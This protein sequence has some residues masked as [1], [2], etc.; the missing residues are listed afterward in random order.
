MKILSAAQVRSWDQYTI[1]HEPISSLNLME[2]AAAAC[3]KWILEYDARAEHFIVVCGK[4]NNGGD[5]LALARL[6]LLENYRVSVYIAEQG[7]PGTND[8]QKNLVRLREIDGH[9]ISFIHPYSELPVF[10]ANTVIIDALFGTG[11]TR[12]LEGFHAQLVTHINQSG[13]PVLSID[14]P[15]GLMADSSSIGFPRIKATHTLS[16]QTYKLAFLL[17]ENADA[18]GQVHILEIGLHVDY[19]Q[20][21]QA[22]ME[23]LEQH[24]I[25]GLLKPR[26][27][28]GHKGDYGKLLLLAGSHGKMGAAV[29]AAHAAMRSGVAMLTVHIPKCGYEIL[30][31]SVPEA[32]VSVDDH[33]SFITAMRPDPVIFDAIGI[34]PGIGTD[35]ETASFMQHLLER[36]RHPLVLDAD[37]LNI[38]SSHPELLQKIPEYSIL[39]PHPKEFERLFGDAGNDFARINLAVLKAAELQSIIILKGHYSFIAVPDG[40]G[41]FNSTG[42]AGMATGGS[43][44]VLTGFLS[45]LLAQGYPPVDAAKLGVYLHGLAGDFAAQSHSE[46]ALIATDIIQSAGSAFLHLE[47]VRLDHKL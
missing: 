23:L 1:E 39:T 15:S 14:L 2:Q 31:T 3:C 5:G 37:A 41:F 33:F 19:L 22:S 13:S 12:P 20:L 9:Q 43:G 40:S 44:D 46:N 25:A 21:A 24:E 35:A 32:M 29:L 16:F 4:G 7:Q 47:R 28:F 42:N 18:T 34:G 45:G 17:A 27:C 36:Y 6:L 26:N 38:L 11:L 30:Q 10:E 8:F